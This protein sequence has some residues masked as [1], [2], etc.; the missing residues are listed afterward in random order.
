MDKNKIKINKM[1]FYVF[2]HCYFIITGI[3]TIQNYCLEDCTY[4]IFYC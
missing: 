4:N 2:I 1:F 3:M